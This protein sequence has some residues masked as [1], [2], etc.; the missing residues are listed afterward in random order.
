MLIDLTEPTLI[1]PIPYPNRCA[2]RF[3]SRKGARCGVF[4]IEFGSKKVVEPLAVEVSSFKAISEG[5]HEVTTVIDK[6]FLTDD[7]DSYYY[8]ATTL[9]RQGIPSYFGP[10]SYSVHF[11]GY[12]DNQDKQHWEA[13]VSIGSKILFAVV[14]PVKNK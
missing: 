12:K 13:T 9:V 10:V 4:P 1:D 3:C 2:I 14:I 8:C 11:R 5:Y 7:L 6:P